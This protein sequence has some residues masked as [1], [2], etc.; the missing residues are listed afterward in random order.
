MCITVLLVLLVISAGVGVLGLNKLYNTARHATEQDVELAQRAA[1]IQI[2][3][4][5]ERRY[6]KDAF[7]NFGDET[8]FSSYLQKWSAA[9]T[10]LARETAAA[11]Q[12]QLNDADRRTLT[13][14]SHRDQPGS[15]RR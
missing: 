12:L 14:P 5:N 13:P 7:I 8:R 6:E 15:A 1:N 2:L 10:A 4:L 9:A 11:K 3:V